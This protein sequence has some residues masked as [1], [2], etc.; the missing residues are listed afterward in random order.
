MCSQ[1][2]CGWIGR[3]EVD[4]GKVTIKRKDGPIAIENGVPEGEPKSKIPKADAIQAKTSYLTT[5]ST[6]PS[7]I[8]ME[9]AYV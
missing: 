1:G 4:H 7:L 5:M 9:K 2:S 8:R 6:A 3:T